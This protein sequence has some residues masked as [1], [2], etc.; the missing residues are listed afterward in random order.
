[1][2]EE[3]RDRELLSRL[4]ERVQRL[5][6]E[7]DQ[8]RRQTMSRTEIETTIDPLRRVVYGVVGALLLGLITGLL[9][10]VIK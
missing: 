3:W 4:D 7:L 9:A 2:G 1:V 6:L 8:H 10:M 5:S